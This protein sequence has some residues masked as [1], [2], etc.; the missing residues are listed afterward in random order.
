[1]ISSLNSTLVSISFILSSFSLNCINSLSRLWAIES[2]GVILLVLYNP[3]II[4]SGG[5]RNTDESQTPVIYLL[6]LIFSFSACE[7]VNNW[8]PSNFFIFEINLLFFGLYFSKNNSTVFHKNNSH[9]I[10]RCYSFST[11]FSTCILFNFGIAIFISLFLKT[12]S[13]KH[14]LTFQVISSILNG[15]N[16][17]FLQNVA[18]QSHPINA[19]QPRSALLNVSPGFLCNVVA[20]YRLIG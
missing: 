20:A 2:F 6:R 1:M 8:L 17:P 12:N 13:A 10:D 3:S 16:F 11:I 14:L 9:F 4:G 19:W 7:H 18:V 15:R 5:D